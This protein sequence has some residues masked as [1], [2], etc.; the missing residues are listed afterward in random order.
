MPKDRQS[1]VRHRTTNKQQISSPTEAG[2]LKNKNDSQV[3]LISI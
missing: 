1:A 2:V 3:T